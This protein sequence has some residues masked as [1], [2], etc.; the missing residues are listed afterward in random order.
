MDE[1]ALAR[2]ESQ[3]LELEG[4]IAQLRKSLRHWQTLELDYEGLREEFSLLSEDCSAQ[5]ALEA[6]RDFKAELVDQQEIRTLFGFD[7]GARRS[8]AQVVDLL[9]KRV[10]YV[11]KNSSTIKKQLSDTEKKRNALLLAK[12]PDYRE[13]AGLPL[14]EVTE[15]L[16]DSGNVVSS[17]LETVQSA[18]PQLMEVLKKAG[19]ND[20]VEKDGIVTTASGPDGTTELN[21]SMPLDSAVPKN[22]ATQA[23]MEQ[24]E[25]ETTQDFNDLPTFPDSIVQTPTFPAEKSHVVERS[26]TQSSKADLD[27]DSTLDSVDFPSNPNDTEEN[28]ALRREML[29]Y[30]HSEIGPI[31]AQLELEDGVSDIS[32]DEDNDQLFLDSE[33]DDE[34]DEEDQS[35]DDYGQ[36]K[37]PIISEKY[38]RKME[39]LEKKLGLKSMQNLGPEPDLP[40]DVINEF[41]KPPAAEAARKAAID[42]A[43]AAVKASGGNATLD[44]VE[45]LLSKKS[46]KKV[47]FA[48][49]LD[50]AKE[51]ELQPPLNT[52]NDRL[53]KSVPTPPVSGSVV[54][55][56]PAASNAD[57]PAL[58]TPQ[59]KKVSRFKVTR[60]ATPQTPLLP[61]PRYPDPNSSPATN[62]DTTVRSD[63]IMSVEIVER[64]DPPTPRKALPPDP[65]DFDE[66]LHKQAIA[67]EYYRSRNKMIQ[68][69]GG[70]V[71]DGEDDNYGELTAP[72]S[73]VDQETGKV[74]KISRFKAARLQ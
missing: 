20:L 56:V 63:N 26:L 66:S 52:L 65:Y 43:D 74:R 1:A 35:E 54:E 48:N 19:V 60:D 61:P 22:N 62:S 51:P 70:F 4:Q 15:E 3:R 44:N 14:T 6:A 59:P 5:E 11:C 16:D 67:G 21:A 24:P 17:K 68:R 49:N 34:A 38:R 50:I 57:S 23:S 28:A 37:S 27:N 47:S 8:P 69:Q 71:R 12:E 18:A 53:S 2:I 9:S 42:R 32:Y 72:L 41:D 13:E 45:R 30:A 40:T 31:V 55:H 33:L 29:E 39:D 25:I 46:K 10:D 58:S 7:K 73:L 64:P 36:S